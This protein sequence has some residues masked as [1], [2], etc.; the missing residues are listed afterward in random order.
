[1]DILPPILN[2]KAE[3]YIK[4]VDENAISWT[5]FMEPFSNNLWFMLLLMA[6]VIS[7]IITWIERF[8]IEP[9][10]KKLWIFTFLTNLWI[11]MKANAGGKPSSIHKST[12]YRIIMFE[13]LLAGVIIWMAYRASFT[14]ELSVIK[15]KLPFHDLVTF[16][17]SDFK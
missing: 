8:F 9:S 14:S 1:M 13:C 2:A 7:C 5:A 16:F 15:L 17:K 3:L 4:T 10:D 6:V 12:T 11:T